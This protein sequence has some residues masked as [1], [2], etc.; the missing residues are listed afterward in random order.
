MSH[1]AIKYQNHGGRDKEGILF[2]YFS[3]HEVSLIDIKATIKELKSD[4]VSSA[5]QLATN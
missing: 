3:F 4:K 2:P 1:I 5:Y